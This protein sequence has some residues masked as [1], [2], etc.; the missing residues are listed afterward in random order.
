MI[1]AL[2]AAIIVLTAQVPGSSNGQIQRHEG[3]SP[4]ATELHD[5]PSTL[6]MCIK[7]ENWMMRAVCNWAHF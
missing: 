1:R 4:V 3:S 5:I 6:L 7:I 2:A